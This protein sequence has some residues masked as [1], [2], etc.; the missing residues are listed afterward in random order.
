MK[1]IKYIDIKNI[2]EKNS[3]EVNS[4]ISNKEEFSS[5]KTILNSSN[6]DLSFFSNQKY[7]ND[8]KNIKA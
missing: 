5:I 2:L 8:F 6:K 4:T 7:A 1:K 3:I